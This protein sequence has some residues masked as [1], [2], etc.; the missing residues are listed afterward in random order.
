MW[1]HPAEG[2]QKS[3]NGE[4][5][6]LIWALKDENMSCEGGGGREKHFR[7]F[8]VTLTD[9]DKVQVIKGG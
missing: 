4:K 8:P 6:C 7:H 5:N 2:N 3:I 9:T 1:L